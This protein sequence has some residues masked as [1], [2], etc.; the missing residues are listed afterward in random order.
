[1]GTKILVPK[2]LLVLTSIVIFQFL[3]DYYTILYP[4]RYEYTDTHT[5]TDPEIKVQASDSWKHKVSD[6][7]FYSW[8]CMMSQEAVISNIVT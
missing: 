4:Q 8:I 6:S 3:E 7:L 5:L 1:M 2:G